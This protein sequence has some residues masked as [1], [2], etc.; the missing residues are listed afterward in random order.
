MSAPVRRAQLYVPG[1]NLKMIAKAA[2]LRADSI[3]LD[4]EDAV[5]PSEKQKARELLPSVLKETEFSCGELC[6]R[7]NSLSEKEGPRD[8]ELAGKMDAIDTVVVPKAE[9]RLDLV[10]KKTGK[11]VLPVIESPKGILKIEEIATTEGTDALAWAGADLSMMAGGE[12]SAYERN[13]YV[14]TRI[15]L[16]SRAYG[17]E[18]IDKVY[19]DVGNIQGLIDEAENSRR[20]GFSGKQVIHPTHLAPVEKVFSPSEAQRLW[21]Q[22][23][24]EAFRSE[25]VGGRGAIRLDGSLIDMVHVRIAERIVSGTPVG[26]E[27]KEEHESGD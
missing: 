13:V 18:P 19:F 12:L 17:L 6:L 11:R 22:R 1:N 16:T 23:V 5:P 24:L 9:S 27:V 15:A 25:K 20:Y 8:M 10:S 26:G 21:A 3:I 14:L 7:I 4:L 2:T